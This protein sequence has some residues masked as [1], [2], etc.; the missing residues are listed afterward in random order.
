MVGGF[1]G[2]YKCIN[3]DQG[4]GSGCECVMDCQGCSDGSSPGRWIEDGWIEGAKIAVSYQ[5][6]SGEYYCEESREK[7]RDQWSNRK[8]VNL[9]DVEGEREG[10]KEALL[11]YIE[12]LYEVKRLTNTG[13]KKIS[14]WWHK[15]NEIA[16]AK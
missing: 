7:Y 10:P 3:S 16:F 5:R 13:I 9:G 15:E 4:K 12:N 8:Q 11:K 6:L 14:E 1:T 2:L